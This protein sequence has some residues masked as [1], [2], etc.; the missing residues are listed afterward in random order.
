MQRRHPNA[1]GDV[2]LVGVILALVLGCC[3]A[4]AD[5]AQPND[6]AAMFGARPSVSDVSLSPDGQSI[7]FVVSMKGQAAALY[8]RRL[9][10]GAKPLAALAVGGKPDRMGGCS[11]VANDRLVCT[12]WGVVRAST[13]L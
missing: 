4:L 8:T 11:W 10:D 3:A 12:I 1:D 13:E 2:K 7:A 5:G 6:A 9:A